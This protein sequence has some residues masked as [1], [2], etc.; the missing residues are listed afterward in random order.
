MR[1]TRPALRPPKAVAVLLAGLCALLAA[2]CDEIKVDR[3]QRA[4]PDESAPAT[5]S[6]E[7]HL[8]GTR[9]LT[10]AGLN[11]QASFNGDGSRIVWLC[12]PGPTAEFGISVMNADGSSPAPVET[13]PGRRHD[14]VFTPE[15][16]SIL[17]AAG[18][19]AAAGAPLPADDDPAGLWLFD[20]SLDLWLVGPGELAPRRLTTTPGY[21]AEGSYSWGGTRIVCAAQ[22]AGRGALVMMEADGRDARE[23]LSMD[24]YIGGPQVSPD[25]SR[26]VFHATPPGETRMLEIYT[27]DL[28]GGNLSR[29]TSLEATSFVPVWHPSQQWILFASNAEDHDMEL[30]LIRPDGT[31][32]ER[33]TFSPGFDGFPAFSRDGRLLLWTS[34]RGAGQA[35]E[36]QIFRANWRG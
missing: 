8:D 19:D 17:Y 20:A 5:A 22:R 35:R 11:R 23:L 10:A 3:R 13:G 18:P 34:G 1:R 24:G 33:V 9:R 25:G 32:L 7:R 2:G 31:G 21:D 16:G 28:T 26:L 6:A 12:R 4:R 15:S 30:Y 14:P 29:L 27:A 36:T